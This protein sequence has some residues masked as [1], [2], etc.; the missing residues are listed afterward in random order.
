ML[1][2]HITAILNVTICSESTNNRLVVL[3]AISV[4][5]YDKNVYKM[6]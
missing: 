5:V 4:T 2:L 6:S 1:K 3:H